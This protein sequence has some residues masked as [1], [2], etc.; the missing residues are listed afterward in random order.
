[1]KMLTLLLDGLYTGL[2]AYGSD[3][4]CIPP[5]GVSDER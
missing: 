2:I 4:W 3:F 1:M 5:E